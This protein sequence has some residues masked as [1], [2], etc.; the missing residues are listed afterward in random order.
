MAFVKYLGVYWPDEAWKILTASIKDV[1][2]F[3]DEL[4]AKKLEVWGTNLRRLL[5]QCYPR[6]F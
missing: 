4:L 1:Q 2:A 5:P 3:C 6:A